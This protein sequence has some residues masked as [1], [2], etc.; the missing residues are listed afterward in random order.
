MKFKLRLILLMIA[1]YVHGFAQQDSGKNKETKPAYKIYNNVYVSGGA[2]LSTILY[3]IYSIYDPPDHYAYGSSQSVVFNGTIDYRIDKVSFG[4]CIAYQTATGVPY[5]GTSNQT[6]FIENLSRLN[7]AVRVLYYCYYSSKMEIYVGGRVG[8][9]Y[10]TDAI[11]GPANANAQLTL[12]SSQINHPS[13]QIPV[14]ARFFVAETGLHIEVGVGTPYFLEAGV[15]F[16][17]GNK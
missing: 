1:S 15:T 7:V 8:N 10:W 14:G 2:G 3:T 12:G 16:K 4:G 5:T 9:S 13:I 17:I 11:V 6:E